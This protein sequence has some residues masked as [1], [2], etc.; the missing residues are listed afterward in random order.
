MRRIFRII[1]GIIRYWWAIAIAV[2]VLCLA[3][4]K[5]RHITSESVKTDTQ[6]IDRFHRDSIFVRDSVYIRE[7]GD[8][9][10][11]TKWRT[12]YRDR[13]IRDTIYIT[14]TDSINTVVEVE[15]KL[16]KWQRFKINTAGWIIATMVVG[17]L[18][19][20]LYRKFKK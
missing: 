19:Y 7:K 14:K 13:F 9:V 1:D 12:E 16:T 3:G 2:I 5:T 10:W 15:K 20:I 17:V 11:L 6:Y 4:C 18:I 8:T